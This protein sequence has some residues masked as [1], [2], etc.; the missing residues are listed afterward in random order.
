MITLSD[1]LK[2][3]GVEVV[4]GKALCPFH[5]EKTP[6]FTVFTTDSG[7]ERYHC[8]GCGEDGD[9]VD[10]LTSMRSMSI[11]DAMQM[12][13]GKIVGQKTATRPPVQKQITKQTKPPR[14][15][16]QLPEG[17]AARYIYRYG[18]KKVAFVV[19]RY[20]EEG[21]KKRFVQYTPA[22]GKRWQ[23]GL[24]GNRKRPLYG[25]N[26]MM[27]ADPDKQVLV[28]EGEKCADLVR[29]NFP[30]VVV[31]SWCGGTGSVQN[32]D[33][34]PLMERKKILLCADS[35]DVGYLC[36]AGLAKRLAGNGRVVRLVLPTLTH[37]S[38]KSTD[39]GDIIQSAPATVPTW[40][41]QNTRPWNEE[42][43]GRMERLERKQKARRET[44]VKL[45][46]NR[47]ALT[48]NDWF[49][50]VECG[51]DHI[52]I[53]MRSQI[54]QIPTQQLART[55]TLLALC[56]DNKFWEDCTGLKVCNKNAPAIADA[57][58]STMR[59]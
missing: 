2:Q 32:T 47:G 22:P 49:K 59:K 27:K 25:L 30:K 21:G 55:S 37:D 36:M 16:A 50:V 3:D 1:A 15:I 17:Y 18:D 39:I 57:I 14:I 7:K 5:Q 52:T 45:A 54:T 12:V 26:S 24:A 13:N 8:F 53:S 56:P 4:S 20:E 43:Q 11:K 31:V 48:D 6:S 28:V 41:K 9:V 29:K 51:D 38:E 34:S 35:D 10:W 44:K 42:L 19:Q 58:L 33:W 23:I 40:I 46:R